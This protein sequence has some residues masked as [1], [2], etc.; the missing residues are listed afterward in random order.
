MPFRLGDLLDR[1]RPAGAPGAAAEGESRREEALV[2]ELAELSA[3]LRM[4]DAAADDVVATARHEAERIAGD[5]DRRAHQL[6]AELADRVAVAG[7][8]DARTEDDQ[9]DDELA[10][11]ADAAA[12]AIDQRR[13]AVH[14]AI[15][16]LVAAAVDEIWQI[17]EPDP[18]PAA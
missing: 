18:E 9:V 5:G 6:R 7:R 12:R 1:I 2:D 8:E 14:G 13:R 16:R 3:A 11:L 15:D 4:M 10:R 17:V